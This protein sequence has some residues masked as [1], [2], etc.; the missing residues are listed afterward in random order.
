MV[1]REQERVHVR[2]QLEGDPSAWSE[3]VCNAEREDI[4]EAVTDC[5]GDIEALC[6]RQWKREELGIVGYED[7]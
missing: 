7:T 4:L 1:E 3:I 2:V 5:V 6:E